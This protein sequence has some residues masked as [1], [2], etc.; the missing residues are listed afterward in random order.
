KTFSKAIGKV[1][2]NV[3]ILFNG[4]DTFD[5]KDSMNIYSN[6]V[7]I[8]SY[9]SGKA[10]L[11]YSA[12]QDYSKIIWLGGQG[13]GEV[14]VENLILDSTYTNPTDKDGMPQGVGAAGVGDSVY[15]VEFRNL[16]YGVNASAGPKGLLVQESTAPM[17]TGL[18]EY[19]LWSQGS[20]I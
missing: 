6:N 5:V 12:A 17:R 18:R 3:E 9:G 15:N 7:V 20:D 19:F 16:G 14:T 4:G 10:T 11:K 1:N 2:D 13:G 8:G